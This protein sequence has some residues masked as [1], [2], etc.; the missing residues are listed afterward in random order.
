MAYMIT[1]SLIG[2][3]FYAMNENPYADATTEDTSWA[4]FMRTLRREPSIP[5]EAMQNGIDFENLVTDILNDRANTSDKWYAAAAK[6]AQ[7]IKGARLQVPAKRF[8]TIRGMEIM[9]YGRLDA[10]KAG[11]VYDIKFTK[12]YEAGKY[13]DSPQH[14]MYLDIVPEADAFTYLASDGSNVWPETYRRDETSDIVPIVEWLFSW[15]DTNGLM[16]TYKKLWVAK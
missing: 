11:V 13:F 16:D 5:T 12:H 2:S 14:P 4:D 9:L 1:Q 3:W 8:V 10:L 7:I 15:F 6:I